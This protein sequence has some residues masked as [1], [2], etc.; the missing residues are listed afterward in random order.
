MNGSS[1]G[2]PQVL[3]AQA[4]PVRRAGQNPQRPICARIVCVGGALAI[5]FGLVLVLL[6]VTLLSDYRSVGAQIVAKTIPNS[7]RTG[8]PQ[9]YRKILG[10]SYLFGG[11]VFAVVGIVVLAK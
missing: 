4:A 6:G 1:G 7:L 8:D 10:F 2:A 9:R 5:V 3:P 11:I